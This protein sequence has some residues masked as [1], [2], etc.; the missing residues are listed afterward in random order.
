MGTHNR[1]LRIADDAFPRAYLEIL[2]IDPDAPRIQRRRWFDFDDAALQHAVRE[3]PR[4]AHF[5][6]SVE[7]IARATKALAALGIDRGPTLDAQRE[8]PSGMLRWR[9]SMR[10]DGQRLMYGA[11]PTLI[12]WDGVHPADSMPPSGVELSA[13]AVSHPR[14]QVL[15]AAYGAIGL[16][17]VSAAAGPPSV[18]AMLRTPKGPVRLD[19]GGV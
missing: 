15:A 16:S 11:L 4:L 8:T 3:T 6:A 19:S 12:E 2:A 9:I 1:L 13:L 10:D 7:D 14:P 18:A 5:V 17:Q